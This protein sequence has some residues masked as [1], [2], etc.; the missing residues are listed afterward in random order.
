MP[1]PPPPRAP[2]G[3]EDETQETMDGEEEEITTED[4]S[5]P[6]PTP[7]RVSYC[8][9]PPFPLLD[10]HPS[11]LTILHFHL[12]LHLHLRLCL[13]PPLK[14]FRKETSQATL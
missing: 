8:L 5:P 12:R 9:P 2:Y 14:L 10:S 11:V 4:V 3:E 1:P 6:T 7:L 13:H